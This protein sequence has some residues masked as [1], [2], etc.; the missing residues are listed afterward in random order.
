[1]ISLGRIQNSQIQYFIPHID[2]L[3][4]WNRISSC[5]VSFELLPTPCSIRIIGVEY[6]SFRTGLLNPLRYKEV[7]VVSW[8]SHGLILEIPG[9]MLFYFYWLFIFY[10]D[11]FYWVFQLLNFV[12]NLSNSVFSTPKHLLNVC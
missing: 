3:R 4:G 8:G 10:G 6:Q 7:P 1:M 5:H 11:E 12:G 2:W 9:T